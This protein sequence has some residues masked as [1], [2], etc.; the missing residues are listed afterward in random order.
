MHVYII[1]KFFFSMEVGCMFTNST[2]VVNAF[3]VR[4]SLVIYVN[5]YIRHGD[6]QVN[7]ASC[8]YVLSN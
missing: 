7:K 5:L 4:A 3:V 1:K 8:L 6:I 2:S